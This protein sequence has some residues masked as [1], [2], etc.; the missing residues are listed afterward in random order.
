M[1]LAGLRTLAAALIVATLSWGP[2]IS[3][4]AAPEVYEQLKRLAGDW[5]AELPG[6]GK[7]T[8]SVRLASNGK[9][10]EEIIGTPENNELSVYSLDAEKIL[11]THY[12]AMTPDG[13]Q[14]RLQTA[15]FKSPPAHL[16]FEF[17]NSTN[18]ASPRAPHMRR[19]VM[20]IIDQDHYAEK[21]TKTEKG[22][23][24]EFELNFV[25]R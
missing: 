9:A 7:I 3:L 12:C 4:A 6:F 24:T 13:H 5:E 22:H 18:L 1:R 15:T 25:R 17:L 20:T 10:I 23:D 8:A 2:G 11:L 16:D 14:V 21:W 19:M